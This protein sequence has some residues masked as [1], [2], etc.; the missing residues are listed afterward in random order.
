MNDLHRVICFTVR[1]MDIDHSCNCVRI[2]GIKMI[3]FRVY[4][5]DVVLYMG[6]IDAMN[7]YNSWDGKI[8]NY[9]L[10]III[11]IPGLYN[12]NPSFDLIIPTF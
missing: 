6:N 7:Y 4:A 11:K 2:L 3:T 1:M 10:E 9:S 5:I 12:C 8:N